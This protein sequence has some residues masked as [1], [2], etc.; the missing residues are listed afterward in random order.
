MRNLYGGSQNKY[1]PDSDSG[2]YLL[3][4]GDVFQRDYVSVKANPLEQILSTYSQRG[5]SYLK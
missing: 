4:M 5:K 2:Q 1:V 3:P